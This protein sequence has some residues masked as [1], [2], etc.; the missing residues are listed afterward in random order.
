MI[1]ARTMGIMS[2]VPRPIR[3]DTDETLVLP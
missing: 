3:N 1:S 2:I